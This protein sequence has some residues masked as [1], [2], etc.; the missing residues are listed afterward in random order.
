MRRKKKIVKRMTDL[1]TQKQ[2]L[3]ISKLIFLP[4]LDLH[5]I[6]CAH[7][8]EAIRVDGVGTLMTISGRQLATAGESREWG[9]DLILKW[10]GR[11]WGCG[12]ATM[13]GDSHSLEPNQVDGDSK[14]R[15]FPSARTFC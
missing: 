12:A 2:V 1:K 3:L 13:V 8:G 6:V 15:A 5:D 10:F 14:H 9:P 4:I 7:Q 11:S